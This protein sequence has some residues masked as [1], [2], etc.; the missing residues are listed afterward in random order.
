MDFAEKMT[1]K[2]I[3]GRG[4]SDDKGSLIAIM[5]VSIYQPFSIREL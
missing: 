5:Y 3:W 2:N 1:G 4:S